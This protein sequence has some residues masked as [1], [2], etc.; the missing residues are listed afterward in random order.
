MS[1]LIILDDRL[2]PEALHGVIEKFVTDDGTDYGEMEIPI[3]SSSQL[4]Y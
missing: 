4:G 1:A 2:S 3:H